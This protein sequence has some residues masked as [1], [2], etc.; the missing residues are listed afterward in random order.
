[1]EEEFPVSNVILF[2]ADA[3]SYGGGGGSNG[4]LTVD[5]E[6]GQRTV[7]HEAAHIYWYTFQSWLSEGGAELLTDASFGEIRPPQGC[8]LANS[9]AELEQ[10]FLDITEQRGAS[11]AAEPI[12]SSGCDYF[13]GRSLFAELYEDLG[14]DVFQRGFRSLYHKIRVNEHEDECWGLERAVCCVKAVVRRR[15]SA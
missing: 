3:T 7:T 2:V 14:S 15:R 11:E 6:S 1:M 10:L 8:S 13:L 9:L 5:P 12:Y 4:I